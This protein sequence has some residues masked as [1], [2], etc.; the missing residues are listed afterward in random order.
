[1]CYLVSIYSYLTCAFST[2]KS[3]AYLIRY[4]FTHCMYT[5][6]FYSSLFYSHFH[7]L[8]LFYTSLSIV[9]FF[10]FSS[11]RRH[12]RYWRDWS[13]DVC[14][15]DLF[16]NCRIRFRNRQLENPSVAPRPSAD[17]LENLGENGR[18]HDGSQG[19]GW[20]SQP[21]EAKDRKSVV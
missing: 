6:L 8:F 1:M 4:H 3:V 20:A 17:G 16:S 15:S 10:F 12:T 9:F 14:S 19:L 5:S 2:T 21:R 13:S 18:D 7:F 11:R